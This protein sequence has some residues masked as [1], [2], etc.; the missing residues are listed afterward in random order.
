MGMPDDY[1]LPPGYNDAYHICGD[2]VCVPVV[3]YIAKHVLEPL[4]AAPGCKCWPPRSRHGHRPLRPRPGADLCRQIHRRHQGPS[5]ASPDFR[6]LGHYREPPD[7][8]MG[9]RLGLGFPIERGSINGLEALL[10]HHYN[11][12]NALMNG[13]VPARPADVSKVLHPAQVVQ[14]MAGAEIAEKQDPALRLPRQSERYSAMS[15]T[16]LQ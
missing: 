14:V 10:Y 15:V 6:P 13:T 9:N 5:T 11:D 8:R 4:L 3:R 12:V 2:G 7:R 16:S 1:R